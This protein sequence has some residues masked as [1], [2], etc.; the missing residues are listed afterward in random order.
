MDLLFLQAQNLKREEAWGGEWDSDE[1]HAF[2]VDIKSATL[3][4][5]CDQ[6][7]IRETIVNFLFGDVKISRPD[8][9]RQPVPSFHSTPE[10]L[11]YYPSPMSV[12]YHK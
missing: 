9:K 11:N 1:A 7:T 8:W 3:T 4:N 12:L 6:E 2:L 5:L 10:T